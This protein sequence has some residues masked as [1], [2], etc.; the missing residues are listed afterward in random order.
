[1]KA[2][3]FKHQ[4]VV[5]AEN[6]PEYTPLPALKIKSKQGEVVF[7]MGLSFYERLRVL[8]FGEIWVSLMTFNNPLTPSFHS[9]IRKDVYSHPDDNINQFRRFI[10]Y[11]KKKLNYKGYE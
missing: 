2:K 7:C 5:F 4:N 10:D 8:I 6:Q 11:L 9:T 1:M 3:E